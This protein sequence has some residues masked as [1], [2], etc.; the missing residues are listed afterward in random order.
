MLFPCCHYS[1]I[2]GIFYCWV[3]S[4]F[5]VASLYSSSFWVSRCTSFLFMN[6]HSPSF[7]FFAVPLG[8]WEGHICSSF[9][10]FRGN[11]FELS[12]S[13][14]SCAARPEDPEPLAASGYPGPVLSL[15]FAGF[16]NGLFAG[17]LN[18]NWAL[19]LILLAAWIGPS[20]FFMELAFC[21]IL[22][23]NKIQL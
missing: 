2:V 17:N 6:C 5:P 20:L 4:S 3:E 16:F 18:I 11:P 23:F 10:V 13:H 8:A 19:M 12:Q 15:D 7:W 22:A 14:V 1:Q 21:E 9:I